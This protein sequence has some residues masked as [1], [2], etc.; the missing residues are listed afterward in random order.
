MDEKLKNIRASSL[1]FTLAMMIQAEY[2]LLEQ[3]RW[4]GTC[5]PK[6]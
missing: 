6:A 2:Q 3:S 4:L 5:L 1:R